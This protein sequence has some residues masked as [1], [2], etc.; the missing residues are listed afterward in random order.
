[1]SYPESTIRDLMAGRLPWPQV[2]QMMSGYKDADRFTT[3][4]AVLQ[5]RV[6]WS[7]SIVLPLTTRLYVVD[8]G[9]RGAVK[10][11]CGHELCDWREHW[12]LHARV[13]VRDTPELLAEVFPQLACDPEWMEVREFVCPGC[14][15]LLEVEPAVPGY[16]VTRDFEPDLA[17]FYRDWLDEEP[18]AW[19]V[20]GAP[21]ADG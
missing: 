2:H 12:K 5:A 19:A 4:R 9:D 7:E 16:P 14:G 15:S 6:P 13:L 21:G 17:A 10:C 8:L 11:E 20:A 3:F 1:M 18:P